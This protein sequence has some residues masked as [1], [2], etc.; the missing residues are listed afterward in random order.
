MKKIVLVIGGFRQCH[1]YL[2]NDANIK[3]IWLLPKDAFVVHD[4]KRKSYATLVYDDSLTT[5]EIIN[6]VKGINHTNKIDYVAV[7]HDK[8]QLLGIDIANALNLHVFCNL[9]KDTHKKCFDKNYMRECM[10]KANFPNVIFKQI[11]N[12]ED[13]INFMAENKNKC[14]KFILKPVSGTG[15]EGIKRIDKELDIDKIAINGTHIIEEYFEGDEYSV[16]CMSYKKQHKLIALTKKEICPITYVEK[17]HSVPANVDG[18]IMDLVNT[19]MINFLNMIGIENGPTHSEIKIH[20]KQ[21]KVIETHTRLGGDK[22]NELISNS[23]NLD[24]VK[25]SSDL[26]FMHDAN[27]EGIIQEQFDKIDYKTHCKKITSIAFKFPQKYGKILNIKGLDKVKQSLGYVS[28]GLIKEIGE[29][30]EKVKHS[31]DRLCYCIC[32]ADNLEEA[33]KRAK[34]ALNEIEYIINEE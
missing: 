19:Y 15:S 1:T 31:F 26:T 22:I 2:Q 30:C 27:Y 7:F 18:S 32:E 34:D 16:E 8:F 21:I 3:F 13:L 17:G 24:I 6:L 11:N 14:E 20:N 29:Q 5:Q 12:K 10:Q 23:Y 4:D 28:H 9:S 33:Q 25:L